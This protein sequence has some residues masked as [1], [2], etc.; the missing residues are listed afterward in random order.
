MDDKQLLL[1]VL[2]SGGSY[3]LA[4]AG[5]DTEWKAAKAASGSAPAWITLM[6]DSI[7]G[8][9]VSTDNLTLAMFPKIRAGLLAAGATLYG[10]HISPYMSADGWAAGGG[11]AGGTPAWVVNTTTGRSW[12]TWGLSRL[13]LYASNANPN[14]YTYTSPY[15]CTAMDIVYYNYNGGN[16]RY[17]LDGGAAVQVNTTS[18]KTFS[19]VQLSGLANTTHTLSFGQQS[20]DYAMQICGVTAYASTVGIGF[21]NYAYGGAGVYG[22]GQNNNSP[23]D[24]IAPFGSTA[25]LPCQPHLAILEFGINDCQGS[26]TAGDYTAALVRFVNAFR[27]G[28]ANCSILLVAPSNPGAASEVTTNRFTNYA[29]W[30]LYKNAMLAV[31]KQYGCAYIDIDAKWG[32]KTV[33][34]G[35][36][37]ANQPHPIDGG[38][39]DIANE[40][41]KLI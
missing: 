11:W 6:G 5:W 32:N 13:M 10:D 27:T 30:Y 4:P 8:G 34:A 1:T 19:R 22:Y 37:R 3:L 24:R 41:L 35:F 28:R 20:G 2:K 15:A 14:L 9:A 7:G 39:A 31:A 38:H 21:T 40:I 33:T 17:S 26:V 16:W 18:A 23:A 29:N 36:H 25:F 12:Y